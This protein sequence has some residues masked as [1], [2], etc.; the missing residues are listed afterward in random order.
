MINDAKVPD[1]GFIRIVLRH[2]QL[3]TSKINGIEVAYEEQY[4]CP[5]IGSGLKM[6]PVAD[7]KVAHKCCFQGSHSDCIAI[8][9]GYNIGEQ[10]AILKAQG[11]MV[12]EN[13]IA[14][15]ILNNLIQKKR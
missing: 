4:K 2:K 1:A 10:L 5:K 14:E 9:E 12:P 6:C 13:Y 7:N 11:D 8:R 15:K 3:K